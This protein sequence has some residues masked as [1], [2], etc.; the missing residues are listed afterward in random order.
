MGPVTWPKSLLSKL[1][2]L[3]VNSNWFVKLLVL[4]HLELWF[5]ITVNSFGV[6]DNPENMIEA[7]ALAFLSTPEQ[8]LGLRTPGPGPI[9]LDPYKQH[10]CIMATNPTVPN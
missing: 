8:V 5:L 7:G 3:D 2:G 9:N 10:P 1:Q 6:A 4:H